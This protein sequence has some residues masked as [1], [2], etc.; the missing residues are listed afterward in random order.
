MNLTV[1][2]RQR[3]RTNR[4]GFDP[5]PLF[6][7]RAGTS[8]LAGIDATQF[9]REFAANR[10]N[11][12]FGDAETTDYNFVLNAGLPLSGGVE[13]YGWATFGKRE[14]AS[15]GFFRWS[16]D[17]RNI[18]TR[19]PNGFLPQIDTE[20]QDWSATGGAKGE[21]SGWNW[22]LS[23]SYGRNEFDFGVSNSLNASLGP[24]DAQTAFDAGGLRFAQLLANLDVQRDV[25]IGGWDSPLSVA[26]GVEWRRETYEI[27]A[28]EPASFIQGPWVRQTAAGAQPIGTFFQVPIGTA[29]PAGAT[30]LAAGAQVFPGFRIPV[31]QDRDAV[32]A[33]STSRPT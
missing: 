7:Q 22:D 25:E 23:L 13:L 30:R 28:G 24:N 19:Y 12:N 14:G 6:S 3:D 1:E 31:D 4:A 9:A 10:L 18:P 5:R 15:N 8:N 20:M 33:I 26:F 21:A 2:Y 32:S 27:R 17:V 29:V 16:S 11:H